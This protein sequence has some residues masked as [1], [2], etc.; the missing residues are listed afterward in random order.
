MLETKKHNK[1][2]DELYLKELLN[3]SDLDVGRC[4]FLFQKL[5]E[6]ALGTVQPSYEPSVYQYGFLS[7][8]WTACHIAF[9]LVFHLL[10]CHLIKPSPSYIDV[11]VRMNFWK[12][13]REFVHIHNHLWL[14][15]KA[16]LLFHLL[17]KLSLNIIF[18]SV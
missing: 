9:L 7:A 16:Y 11:D 4:V 8:S 6:L 12:S 15:D 10:H 13:G 17:L 18:L 2:Y 3:F 5:L 14:V 1:N